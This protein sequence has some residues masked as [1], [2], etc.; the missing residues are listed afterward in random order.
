MSNIIELRL[1]KERIEDLNEWALS[2]ETKE[3]GFSVPTVSR[4]LNWKVLVGGGGHKKGVYATC[5]EA[6]RYGLEN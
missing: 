5:Y 3:S 2:K 6:V 1:E 4:F